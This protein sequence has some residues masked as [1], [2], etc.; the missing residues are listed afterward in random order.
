MLATDDVFMHLLFTLVI[1][2]TV[3]D[4]HNWGPRREDSIYL[5][6]VQSTVSDIGCR[7]S[8]IK[9]VYQRSKSFIPKT[10]NKKKKTSTG[11]LIFIEQGYHFTDKYKHFL[12]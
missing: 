4:N 7:V 10:K 9:R 11:K 12:K 1:P 2:H 5:D 3:I 8:N 6:A